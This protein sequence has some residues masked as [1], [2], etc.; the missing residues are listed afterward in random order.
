MLALSWNLKPKSNLLKYTSNL[1]SSARWYFHEWNTDMLQE[2]HGN[3]TVYKHHCKFLDIIRTLANLQRQ[4][5]K[6]STL[7]ITVRCCAAEARQL[8]HAGKVFQYR[9]IHV[10]H[11]HFWRTGFLVLELTYC[12]A[13]RIR[14]NLRKNLVNQRVTILAI[15]FGWHRH[16]LIGTV[17]S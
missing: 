17:L 13:M 7:R 12:G 15:F 6:L 14:T 16:S 5:N 3:F 11:A 1:Q 4:G 10:W 8:I 2:T 9:D